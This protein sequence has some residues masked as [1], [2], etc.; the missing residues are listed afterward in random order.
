VSFAA[1][2]FCVTS[3]RGL[4]V[5]RVYFIIDSVRKLLD[6]PSYNDIN[7]AFLWNI[8][9]VTRIMKKAFIPRRAGL[10]RRFDPDTHSVNAVPT[11]NVTC[12]GIVN[13]T[14]KNHSK[15]S[16]TLS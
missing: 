14:T 16:Q 12:F 1:I 4:I 13:K 9:R 7:K 2:T 15:G 8:P 5:L 3:K 11:F 10:V 6:I